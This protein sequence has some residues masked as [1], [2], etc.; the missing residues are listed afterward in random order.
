VPSLYIHYKQKSSLKYFQKKVDSIATLMIRSIQHDS[1]TSTTESGCVKT[2]YSFDRH[3]VGGNL[4]T[5]TAGNRRQN[6][7]GSHLEPLILLVSCLE[8]LNPGNIFLIFENMVG[9]RG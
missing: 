9:T 6:G 2:C 1:K 7:Q 4:R 3:R 5:A 8:R